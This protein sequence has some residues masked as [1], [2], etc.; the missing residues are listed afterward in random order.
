MN[1]HIITS[2]Y[3]ASPEDPSGTMGLFVRQF[4]IEF[5]ALG[6]TVVVQP[7]ARKKAYRP[8]PGFAIVPMPWKG[9]D[10]ELASMDLKSPKNWWIFL[11]LFISGIHNTIQINNKYNIDRT[12]CMLAVP[13]GIFGLAGK[14]R[15]NIPYDVWALGSDIWKIR[16]IPVL[17]KM[18]LK[19]VIKN[20]DRVFSDGT[21]LCA[22]VQDLTGVPCDFLHSSRKLPPPKERLFLSGPASL[23]HFLFVGR[24]HVNK[25][26]DLL[27]KAIGC[28]PQDIQ[29]SIR[30]HMFGLGPMESELKGMISE[31]RL[32]RYIH[33]HGP[34]K[35]QE[36]SNYLN[37]VSFLVIPS[38]I[39]SIPV[40]FSDAIQLGTP[41]VAMPVGDLGALIK[42]FECG[43]LADE[44]SAEA[45]A[46]AIKE[47]FQRGED[48]FKDAFSK[49]KTQSSGTHTYPTYGKEGRISGWRMR[50]ELLLESRDMTALSE[51]LGRLQETLAV[52]QLV[53]QPSP[54]TRK[55]A[56]EEAML[57]ALAAFQAKASLI[58]GA[59]KKS[60]CIRQMNIGSAGQPPVMPM[61]M[62]S[63]RMDAAEAA[64]A[65]IEAGESM[66]SVTISGQI[67]LPLE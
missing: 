61:M 52:S 39:E 53:L 7:V 41:V 37:S 30:V 24:Y 54:E 9:G 47:A 14:L 11:H 23:R 48:P 44:V 3:P 28:L 50:S 36:F 27:I 18:L 46:S 29:E 43:L 1:I 22:H 58:A 62:R 64:P 5:A 60:Y 16:K 4:A 57:E 42:E 2:S 51:L 63:A 25:G 32:E 31:M 55:K 6:H 26:P 34:I 59:L 13:A 35:A 15:K 12:L 33:L 45:L 8:E 21:Q 66:V 20:A 56:E 40:V 65:P 10:Q 19:I 17:G 49:V 38:R 67:E